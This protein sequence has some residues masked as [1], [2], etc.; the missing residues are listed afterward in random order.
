[1]EELLGTLFQARN[2][3]HILHW[4]TKS[5]AAHLALGDL[6]DSLVTFADDLAEMYMG[7]HGTDFKIDLN[8]SSDFDQEDAVN[9][10]GQLDSKLESVKDS[11]AQEG[12]LI[13]KFEEVQALV[14]QTKYKLENLK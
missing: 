1:M 13:N 8:N 7:R 2:V 4:K 9:F 3:A 12:F 14:S 11:F 10:I 6:Y 5:F